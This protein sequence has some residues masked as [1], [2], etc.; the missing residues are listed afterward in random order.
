MF[1]VRKNPPTNLT[2]EFG[3]PDAC[4][5]NIHPF[6]IGGKGGHIEVWSAVFD[7]STGDFL[8]GG[9][10]NNQTIIDTAFWNGFVLRIN[11]VGR[12]QWETQITW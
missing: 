10:T 2:L 12:T 1:T 4:D 3:D 8:L 11:N 6:A 5:T 9:I 7:E